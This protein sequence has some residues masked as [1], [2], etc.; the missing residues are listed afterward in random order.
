M[1]LC[2][3]TS[4]F[5]Y[6]QEGKV[7]FTV[8]DKASGVELQGAVIHY[9][10]KHLVTDSKGKATTTAI[11]YGDFRVE[12]SYLGFETSSKQLSLH[13]PH[14]H[15]TIFMN[16]QIDELT[17]VV[18]YAEQPKL[19]SVTVPEVHLN[20]S[21]LQEFS[22]E[23]LGNALK[24]L[25]GVT[26]LNAG[27]NIVKPMIHGMHSSRIVMMNNGV[28]Q[29]DMEWGS[30]HAPNMDV[31]AFDVLHVI[32]GAGALRYGGDAVGGI[33]IAEYAKLPEKEILKGEIGLTSITNGKGGGLNVLLQKG[34]SSPWGFQLQASAKQ[35]GD[36]KTPDYYL[37]NSGA[38]Q[39]A[40]MAQGGYVTSVKK[41]V[42]SYSYF[43]TD[44][45]ILK[46][47][48]IGNLSDLANAINSE[49]P[50]VIEPFAYK[51]D[52]PY[53]NVQHHLAKWEAEK[54]FSFGRVSVNYAYQFNHRL[55][56]DN[57]IGENRNTPSMNIS[58]STH[59]AEVF[60]Q[61]FDFLNHTLD[62][63]LGINGMFQDNTSNPETQVKRLIPD[64]L[65]F[66]GGI[67][68]TADYD[69][70]AKTKLSA[71]I[72]FD[73]NRTDAKKYYY[74]KYWT[75]MDYDTDFRGN[76]IGDY[77]NEWLTHFVISHGVFSGSAGILHHFKNESRLSFNY[78]LAGRA[79][80]PGEL[81]SEGL[82]HSVVSIELGDVRI[83][84]EK[85]HKFSVNYQQPIDFLDGLRVETTLYANMI[86]D[87]IYQIPTGAEYTI[88][89][90]FQ[91]WS[92]KQIDAL[93]AGL[94]V[95]VT[96][97]P[98]ENWQTKVSLSYLYGQDIT[99]D[100]P[101]ISMPPLEWKSEIQYNFKGKRK[102]FIAVNTENVFSQNRYPDYDFVLSN[103][104]ENGVFVDKTVHISEPPKAYFLLGAKA[105]I[106]F[107]FN[108]KNTLQV[109]ANAQNL[110][111]TAYR[112]YL[113]RFRYFADEA[114]RQFQ[115]QC[116]YKF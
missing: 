116:I 96:L 74:K 95:D 66:N 43:N 44:L 111:N 12:V 107:Q 79:P 9:A 80:N 38:K 63:S 99:N 4:F 48:H 77:G 39:M 40:F 14:L 29:E 81:F 51:I 21:D 50:S 83:Q 19:S 18:V 64:Y 76:I 10:D 106:Q 32:K 6:A 31:N 1:Y 55:E 103:I 54:L 88:R 34:F 60:V 113:N 62:I 58:L 68:V 33:V 101:L 94:D 87:Y 8:A 46:A 59:S 93:I 2:F 35:L 3:L 91:V 82:H 89:G 5:G 20:K 45:G 108:N 36:L 13:E 53:Q 72:R 92:Y 114:G 24:K 105:G 7:T 109:N 102:P 61:P 70:T 110:L 71:G 98:A 30:E 22:S 11:P 25:S 28:R 27:G 112:N 17:Q 57:R 15:V 47:A 65:K 78:S 16:E 115:I 69:L 85:A 73:Y 49:E 100:L 56:Y 86:N 23:G 26:S 97:N 90:A 42:L 84:P 52:K 41:M 75:E 104:I 67:F 37:T